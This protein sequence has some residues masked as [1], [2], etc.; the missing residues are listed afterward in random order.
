MTRHVFYAEFSQNP[1]KHMEEAA[2]DP[3]LIDDKD[4]V[5]LPAQ[6]YEGL[7]ETL[8]ILSNPDDARDLREAIVE[9]DAGKFVEHELV[10]E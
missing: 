10:D 4:W 6:K 3:L 2:G 8:R 5:V 7:L 1:A 9:A